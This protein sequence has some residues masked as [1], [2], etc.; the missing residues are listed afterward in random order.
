MRIYK[1][2]GKQVRFFQ[3]L[4]TLKVDLATINS[5]LGRITLPLQVKHLM[6]AADLSQITTNYVDWR[7]ESVAIALSIIEYKNFYRYTNTGNAL[8]NYLWHAA[9]TEQMNGMMYLGIHKNETQKSLMNTVSLDPDDASLGLASRQ[10]LLECGVY[11]R[12]I[13]GKNV[14][15]S[16]YNAT[17]YK[18]IYS[19]IGSTTTE[20]GIPTAFMGAVPVEHCPNAYSFM[21]FNR[22]RIPAPT[23]DG[24]KFSLT[25]QMICNSVVSYKTKVP[26]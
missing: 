2:A 13:P 3:Q 9:G 10:K 14:T 16:W 7:L 1:E 24:D 17:G 5:G 12:A 8:T 23:T 22:D 11:K 18:G 20:T 21:M 25:I 19:P 6:D 4:S 15:F 26:A